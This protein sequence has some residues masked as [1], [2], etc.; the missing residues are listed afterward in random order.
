M[1]AAVNQMIV[2][3][4]GG[5]KNRKLLFLKRMLLLQV[6]RKFISSV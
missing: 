3:V 6:Y 4:F 1:L 2:F 5:S